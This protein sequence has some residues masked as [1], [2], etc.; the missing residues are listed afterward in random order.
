MSSVASSSGR[1]LESVRSKAAS[2]PEFKYRRK[3]KR[4]G[5]VHPQAGSPL[6]QALEATI[7]LKVVLAAGVDSWLLA[8]YSTVWRSAGYIVLPAASVRDA[9]DQFETGDFDLVLLGDSFSV[10]SKERLTCLIHASGSRT[11][12]VSIANPSS[13][14][15]LFADATIRNDSNALLQSMGEL[16]AKESRSWGRADDHAR[17]CDLISALRLR[18]G[19]RT[20]E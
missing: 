20:M 5:C 12:V 2:E 6:A 11:P 9:I 8:T 10:E 4:Y 19:M 17:P 14:R 18:K 1:S 3:P 7:S 16:L 15:D 13:D